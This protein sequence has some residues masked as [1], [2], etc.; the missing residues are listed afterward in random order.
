MSKKGIIINKEEEE[1]WEYAGMHLAIKR[2]YDYSKDHEENSDSE[3][4]EEY[5]YDEEDYQWDYE[6]DYYSE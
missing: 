3:D 5:Y 4:E 1:R 2:D 6:H